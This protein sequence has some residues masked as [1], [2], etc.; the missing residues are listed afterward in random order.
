VS[1]LTKTRRTIAEPYRHG[2]A[3]I[4]AYATP[5]FLLA[6]AL[7]L[8]L[9]NVK[10]SMLCQAGGESAAEAILQRQALEKRL[11]ALEQET[12]QNNMLFEKFIRRLDDHYEITKGAQITE[13]K[14]EAHFAAAAISARL[15]E[16]S[17]PPMPSFAS[18][19]EDPTSLNNA[20]D[21]AMETLDD[22]Q[23]GMSKERTDE[24]GGGAWE[25]NTGSQEAKLVDDL[26][27]W[28][29]QKGEA[30]GAGGAADYTYQQKPDVSDE[31]AKVS[32]A[33]AQNLKFRETLDYGTEQRR[34]GR[35]ESTTDT[36]KNRNI[37]TQNMYIFVHMHTHIHNT[38]VCGATAAEPTLGPSSHPMGHNEKCYD[39]P[40]NCHLMPEVP[41]YLLPTTTTTTLA[42]RRRS[43]SSGRPR[44]RSSRASH[45]GAC[46]STCKTN[47][48]FTTATNGSERARRR[49]AQVLAVCTE[50]PH[51]AGEGCIG[52]LRVWAVINRRAVVTSP[53]RSARR[54]RIDKTEWQ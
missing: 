47:G 45:G 16:E 4:A 9:V 48:S 53:G 43:A 21:G 17:A 13:M 29:E 50:W 30:G 40:E 2:Q 36:K 5:L 26:Y 44:T 37:Q 23:Y 32:E 51:A 41:R 18:V 39:H 25:G 34:N 52:I 42:T 54:L 15:S 19:Y 1:R 20:I 8:V 28:E 35:G 49:A 12:L 7:V 14:N 11:L 3:K 27:G 46:P 10:H 22:Y 38:Q 6:L 31:E 33:P 24:F